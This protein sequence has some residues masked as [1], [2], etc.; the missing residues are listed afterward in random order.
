LGEETATDVSQLSQHLGVHAAIVAVT[1]LIIQVAILALLVR[2][3]CTAGARQSLR[4][5]IREN[6]KK[7]LLIRDIRPETRRYTLR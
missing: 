5:E 2:W 1:I 7:K 6:K 3:T 4:E